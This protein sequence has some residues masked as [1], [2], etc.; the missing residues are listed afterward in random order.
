MFTSVVLLMVMDPATDGHDESSAH[1]SGEQHT[2]GDGCGFSAL[3]KRKHRRNSAD[4]TEVESGVQ[5]D[6]TAAATITSTGTGSL[7]GDE[8]LEKSLAA[9]Q[10]P[11][12]VVISVGI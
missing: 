12:Y 11:E 9:L 5:K 8:P 6:G 4:D 1:D 3:F 7:R 2:E 10:I